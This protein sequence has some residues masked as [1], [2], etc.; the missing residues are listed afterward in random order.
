MQKENNLLHQ[1]LKNWL[2][3][4]EKIRELIR[5]HYGN[6]EDVSKLNNHFN[7]IEESG[8]FILMDLKGE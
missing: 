2:E 3:S 7:K 1:R 8:Y 4:T 5:Q 6:T